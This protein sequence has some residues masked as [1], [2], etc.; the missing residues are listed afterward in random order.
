[1]KRGLMIALIGSLFFGCLGFFLPSVYIERWEESGYYSMGIKGERRLFDFAEETQTAYSLEETYFPGEGKDEADPASDDDGEGQGED[2]VEREKSVFREGGTLVQT[3]ETEDRDLAAGVR[4]KVP[5]EGEI[6]YRDFAFQ[7]RLPALSAPL[8]DL[9]LCYVFS[10]IVASSTLAVPIKGEL[11]KISFVKEEDLLTASAEITLCF[12]LLA[13][14]YHISWLPDYAHF[15]LVI[16]FSVK[17]SEISV[18]SGRISLRCE[19]FDLPEAL[20]IFGC[21]MAFGKRD[22]RTLFGDA[23]KNVFLNAG[24]YG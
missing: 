10:E 12:T 5:I 13:E 15:S 11:E 18:I 4:R 7:G 23:V 1:M 19:T 22:Y 9:E 6:T 14:K 21:N 24:I 2:S 3:F 8:T 20:L 17:D 16:P